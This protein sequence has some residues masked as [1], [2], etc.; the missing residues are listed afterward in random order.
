MNILITIPSVSKKWGGTTSSVKNFYHGLTKL[1]GINC[2]IVSTY[3]TSEKNE[4]DSE[5]LNNSDLI[6]FETKSESWRYSKDLKNYI[7]DNIKNY[8]LV[9]IHTLWTG[10]SYF[11]SKYSRKNNIPYVVTPHGMIEPEALKRKGLKKRIYWSLIEQN[12]FDYASSIHCITKAEEIYSNN[13]SRTKTF[14]VPNGIKKETFLEKKVNLLN[15]ISFIGRFHEIKGLDLLL[16][17]LVNI[18]NLNLIIAGGG[19][20]NYEEYIYNLVKELQLEKRVMFKG[21]ADDKVKKEIFEQSLF[22]V[23]PSYSEG[24]SMVGLEAIMNSTPVL[25]TEKCNFKEVEDFNA[26][27]IMKDNSIKTLESHINLMIKSDIKKMSENAYNLALEKFS[28]DSV[29]KNIYKEFEKIVNE[30]SNFK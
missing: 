7:K 4:V 1:E 24:L 11:A 20:K 13:L 6:L 5:I 16:K 17:S 3:T 15:S 10:T 21:F 9:W 30:T 22:L 2:T 18:R 23:L 27:I 26:G 29:S 14:V 8:D 28:I 25:T 19:E 12:I